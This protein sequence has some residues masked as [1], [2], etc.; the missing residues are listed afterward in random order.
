MRIMLVSFSSLL[1]VLLGGRIELHATPLFSLHGEVIEAVEGGPIIIKAI[2][3]YKGNEK[4]EVYQEY[5]HNAEI[6]N[7]KNWRFHLKAYREEL[8]GTRTGGYVTIAPSDQFTE[9]LV[10]HY[11]C[12]VPAG[13]SNIELT[14]ALYKVKDKNGKIISD[15]SIQLVVNVLPATAE[16][17]ASLRDRLIKRVRQSK[18]SG[19]S[20]E[21]LADMV[22]FTKHRALLPAAWVMIETAPYEYPFGALFSHIYKQSNSDDKLHERAIQLIPRLSWKDWKS[23]PFLYWRMHKTTLPSKCLK[24]LMDDPDLWVRVLTYEAFGEK[25]DDGWTR[26]LLN[27][28]RHAAYP[29]PKM[30]F[31]NLLNELDDD[32][33]DR[34]EKATTKLIQLATRVEGQLE[35]CNQATLSPEAARRVRYILAAIAQRRPYSPPSLVL[36]CLDRESPKTQTFAILRALSDGPVDS[37]LMQ[38]AR[39]RLSA[40][41]KGKSGKTSRVER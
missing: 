1:Y 22:L 25:C 35:H 12:D 11:N 16:N 2:L 26:T 24:R 7:A 20:P 19:V 31:T 40:K 18:Q 21:R 4:I 28:L 34:R 3:T 17:L 23:Y 15:P 8:L 38:E 14:W 13:K 39:A 37:W 32:R 27:E 10:I 9:H 30:E 6:R 36:D 33:F 5:Y 29:L 41:L